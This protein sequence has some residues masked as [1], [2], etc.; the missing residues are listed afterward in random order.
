MVIKTFLS[1]TCDFTRLAWAHLI[2]LVWLGMANQFS[3]LGGGVG[4]AKHGST[5]RAYSLSSTMLGGFWSE[6]DVVFEYTLCT[7]PLYVLIGR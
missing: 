7:L 2:L 1:G 6:I 3:G 4:G 5:S